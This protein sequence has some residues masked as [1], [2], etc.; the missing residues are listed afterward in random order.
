VAIGRK[1]RRD[2]D[3]EDLRG[4]VN[5]CEGL[6]GPPSHLFSS[7]PYARPPFGDVSTS[8]IGD[9]ARLSSATGVM[10]SDASSSSDAGGAGRRAGVAAP[11]GQRRSPRH[12]G[13]LVL[14][15]G[16][17][18]GLGLVI[19]SLDAVCRVVLLEVEQAA[20]TKGILIGNAW[21]SSRVQK[22]HANVRTETIEKLLLA[23]MHPVLEHRSFSLVVTICLHEHNLDLVIAYQPRSAAR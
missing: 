2:S 1:V 7:Y 14:L 11:L 6:V 13:R 5:F 18:E 21:Y 4:S 17:G 20:C 19:L 8:R 22:W 23:Q 3:R 9:G 10:R 15:G 12:Q 16:D